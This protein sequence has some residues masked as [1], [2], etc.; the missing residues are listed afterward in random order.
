MGEHLPIEQRIAEAERRWPGLVFKRK[1]PDE[2]SADACPFCSMV[3]DD[4]F[5]VFADAGYWCRQCGAKGW[6]N[7]NKAEPMSREE[8]VELRLRR[9]E[10]QQEEHERRLNKLEHLQKTRPDLRYYRNLTEQALEYWFSEGIYQDAIDHFH[11]GFC[12]PI[13]N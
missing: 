11:L 8:L 6:L 1:T 12:F 9:L 10:R 2:A 7:E 5:L 3:D 4:G 13:R